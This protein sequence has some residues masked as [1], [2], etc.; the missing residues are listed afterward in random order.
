[1]ITR[2]KS[3]LQML[4][5]RL[6]GQRIGIVVFSGTAVLQCPMTLDQ[7]MVRLV[8][9]SLDT[10]SINVA[11]TDIGAAIRTTIKAF[12]NDGSAGGR[13]MVLITDGE[14]NEG[15]ALEAAKEAAAKKINIYGIGIGTAQGAPLLENPGSFKKDPSGKSVTSALDMAALQQIAKATGGK[16]YAAGASPESA[17][18]AVGAA[19]DQQDKTEFEARHE[20]IHQERYQWFLMPGLFLVLWAAVATPK[21]GLNQKH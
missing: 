15:K 4:V 17:V 3:S 21:N 6:A 11:G 18:A 13:A 8:L 20:V 5:N 9:D 2:A 16:A 14:D 10:D 7:A 19:I 12:E 1:R